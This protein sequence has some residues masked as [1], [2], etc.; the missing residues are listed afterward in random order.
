MF[1]QR[2]NELNCVLML[3]RSG[4]IGATRPQSGHSLL[5]D[6]TVRYD[7][8][9]SSIYCIEKLPSLRKSIDVKINSLADWPQPVI[10]PATSS[11]LYNIFGVGAEDIS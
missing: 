11:L 2:Q 9:M 4:Q 1:S 6:Q 5:C 10:C 7:G 3:D 8:T